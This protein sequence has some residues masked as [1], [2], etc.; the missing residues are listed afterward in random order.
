MVELW[1]WWWW[2]FCLFVVSLVLL[3]T[4]KLQMRNN[5]LS[6]SGF[7]FLKYFTDYQT[8]DLRENR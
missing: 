4:R 7:I 1:W 6:L 3:Q 5:I 8:R 2:V